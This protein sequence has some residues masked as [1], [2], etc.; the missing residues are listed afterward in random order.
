MSQ[1][2]KQ[3]TKLNK[4]ILI[5]RTLEAFTPKAKFDPLKY[6]YFKKSLKTICVFESVPGLYLHD[7]K[8]ISFALEDRLTVT[9]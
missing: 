4:N 2:K 3:T 7:L 1:K 5:A 8:K 6:N 9:K